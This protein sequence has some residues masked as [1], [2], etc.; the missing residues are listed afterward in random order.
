MRKEKFAEALGFVDYI[1]LL[2]LSEVV[3]VEGDVTWYVTPLSDGR[4]AA[5]DDAEIEI[6]RVS[7]YRDKD[8]ALD[9]Q[10]V[11]IQASKLRGLCRNFVREIVKE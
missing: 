1:E 5:W 7:Y 10:K 9:Y 11:G 3:Y 2:D 4:W 8:E 6:D